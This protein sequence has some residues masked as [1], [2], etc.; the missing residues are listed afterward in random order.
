MEDTNEFEWPVTADECVRASGK[1]GLQIVET[2]GGSWNVGAEAT[3]LNHLACS[4]NITASAKKA[5]FSRVAVYNRKRNDCGFAERWQAAIAQGYSRIEALLI[6]RAEDSLKGL[7]IDPDSPIPVMTVA[8]AMNLL[9]L[10][11]PSVEANGT[12]PHRWR[13]KPA[14]PDA[15]RAEIL[16]NVAAVR[17]AKGYE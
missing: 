15:A 7:K 9:K 14:D 17:R 16:K 1:D 11:K 4:C 3:F 6:R 8:E 5:G 12:N 13:M 10:H 2:H